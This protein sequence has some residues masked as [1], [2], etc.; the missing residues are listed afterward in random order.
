MNKEGSPLF[1]F[2][3]IGSRH[4]MLIIAVFDIVVQKLRG[5]K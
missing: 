1:K 4:K 2:L 5:F 3:N